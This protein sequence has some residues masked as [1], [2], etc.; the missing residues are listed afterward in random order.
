VRLR[1]EATSRFG[2]NID[3]Y[4]LFLPLVVDATG[5]AQANYSLPGLFTLHVESYSGTFLG[6][7][8][9]TAGITVI[10]KRIAVQNTVAYHKT[11][12]AVKLKFLRIPWNTP[13]RF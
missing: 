5:P 6:L 12:N 11:G 7:N 1:T 4:L 8:P 3:R 9:L 2:E 13:T 10:R